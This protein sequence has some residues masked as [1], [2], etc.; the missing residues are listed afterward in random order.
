MK[1]YISGKVTGLP[2]FIYRKQFERAELKLR[3]SGYNV[4]NPVKY[5]AKGK[6]KDFTWAQFMKKD[7]KALC[8]CD[9]IYLLKTWRMSKGAR[10]EY[11]IAKAL[12]M[13]IL[14]SAK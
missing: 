11:D 7:I 5:D 1:V 4:Y 12:G 13:E 6:E 3:L 9:A 8:D 14:G 10:L 2:A